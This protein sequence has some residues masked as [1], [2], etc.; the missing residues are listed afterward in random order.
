MKTLITL[1]IL[2]MAPATHALSL[3]PKQVR[4]CHAIGGREMIVS[5]TF[6]KK[7]IYQ[8]AITGV[9]QFD[10]VRISEDLRVDTTTGTLSGVANNS[11]KEVPEGSIIRLGIE[12]L[13]ILDKTTENPIIQMNELHCEDTTF[14]DPFA[15]KLTDF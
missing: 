10:F 15:E 9:D 4:H 5:K 11:S 14:D 2:A 7:G 13:E 6:G 8:V 12:T 3:T 1:A